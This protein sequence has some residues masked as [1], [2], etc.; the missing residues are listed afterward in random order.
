MAKKVLFRNRSGVPLYVEVGKNNNLT[1]TAPQVF[2][3]DFDGFF[4]AAF[5]RR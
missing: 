3:N 1:G 2:D 4:I 5:V